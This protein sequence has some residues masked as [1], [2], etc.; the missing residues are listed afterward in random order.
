MWSERGS[1]RREL[2]LPCGQC[3]GCRLERSRQ[4]AVRCVHESQMHEASSFVTL[5]YRTECLPDNNSLYYRHFQLFMKKLRKK[6]GK[7]V[8]FYMC[9][10]YGDENARPHFHAILFGCWFADR[11]P[12]RK[13]PSGHMLYRSELLDSVWDL[14][15]A[16]IGDFSFESAAYVARYV[17]KKITGDRA[18]A[19]YARLSMDTGEIA[20]VEPEFTRMSLKP[21]IGASWFAKFKDEVFE[22]DYV[23]INGRQM[24]PPKFYDRLLACS[25]SEVAE[26]MEL[27][28]YKKSLA[29]VA[30]NSDD[31]LAVRETVTRARL[32]F[33][34]RTL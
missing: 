25:D 34:K 5:T 9:G 30:D 2:V 23:V 20:Q 3:V 28:R 12:W 21:G 29:I 8:R 24:K 1:I 11:K 10:E 22:N 17:M 4:W 16:E 27:V 15:Q 13:S 6:L 14:G 32:A 7:P 19:H 33:K 18:E 26:F 31:R